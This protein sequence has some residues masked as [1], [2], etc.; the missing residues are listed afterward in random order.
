MTP[1]DKRFLF[2]VAGVGLGVGALVLLMRKTVAPAQPLTVNGPRVLHRQRAAG[3]DPRLVAFL[4]WWDKN[5]EFV[6]VVDPD[7]GVRTDA[8][9]QAS[10]AASGVSSAATLD[11]TPHGRAGALDLHPVLRLTKDGRG[12]LEL[13]MK[14]VDLYERIGVAAEKF[15]LKWGGRWRTKTFPDGDQPHIEVPDWRTLPYPPRG[16]YVA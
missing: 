13:G 3:V 7:G 15:G 12:A 2:I 14:R 8:A 6:I 5:G 1:A 11:A 4:D 9:K 10:F 16:P